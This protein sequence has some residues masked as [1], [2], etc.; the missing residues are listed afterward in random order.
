MAAIEDSKVLCGETS[1]G[2]LYVYVDEH[3]SQ[4]Y[5]HIRYF[6]LD[7]KTD[8][9]KPGVKGIAIPEGN[10]KPVLE[11]VALALKFFGGNSEQ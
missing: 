3:R 9:W 7:R 11:A 4:R 10:I 2:K 8:E 6:Y 5:L 1:L